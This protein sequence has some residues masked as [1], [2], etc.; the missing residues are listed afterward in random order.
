MNAPRRGEVRRAV[1]RG[2][3]FVIVSNDRRNRNLKTVL[4]CRIAEGDYQGQPTVVPIPEDE[5]I[6]GSVV[7]DDVTLLRQGEL[8]DPKMVLSPATMAAVDAGLCLALDLNPVG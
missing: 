7:C 6:T 5:R 4:G 8:A 1:P 2:Q 3:T